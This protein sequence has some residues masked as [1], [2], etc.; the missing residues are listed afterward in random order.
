[1]RVF[2]DT[3]VLLDVLL[4]RAPHAHD[5]ELIWRHAQVGTIAGIVSA[6]SISNIF[7]IASRQAGP[8]AA[9]LAVEACLNTCVV[10]PTDASILRAAL[11]RAG[12]DFEDDVQI[13]T[14]VAEAADVIVTRNG[15]DFVGSP[16][17]VVTPGELLARLP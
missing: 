1:M 16:I 9:S 15:R 11:A 14:A 8:A 2:L 12:V 5:A 6:V 3:N 17:P 4:L 7:Y 13:A 10:G